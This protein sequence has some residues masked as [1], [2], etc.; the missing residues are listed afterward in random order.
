MTYE[1]TNPKCIDCKFCF[2]LKI[3][4]EEMRNW[5]NESVCCCFPITARHEEKDKQPRYE[6][7]AVY[8]A[9]T[10]HDF[11]EGFTKRSVEE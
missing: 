11:C 3:W 5:R 4:N 1:E 2:K 10:E 9:D 7:F 6:H 8:I